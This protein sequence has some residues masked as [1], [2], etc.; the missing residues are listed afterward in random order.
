MY[1]RDEIPFLRGKRNENGELVIRKMTAIDLIG[2]KFFPIWMGGIIIARG[3]ITGQDGRLHMLY[4][5]III[6]LF[7]LLIIEMSRYKVIFTNESLVLESLHGG[8]SI[9]YK[10]IKKI[11]YSKRGG[12]QF[13]IQSDDEKI[14]MQV[15]V[16]GIAEAIESLQD[17]V[18][19]SL[20]EE[21]NAF[22]SNK[23]QLGRS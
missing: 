20:C 15:E 13:I 1:R 11:N 10:D 17:K 22:L 6:T 2:V 16:R 21:A 8:C 9:E 5:S 3:Y 4:T 18:G 19:E 12:G 23:K 14:V 7:I